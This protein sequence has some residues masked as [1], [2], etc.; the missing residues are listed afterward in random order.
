[1]DSIRLI[2]QKR[3]TKRQPFFLYFENSLFSIHRLH[4]NA[5]TMQKLLVV[6]FLKLTK[7]KPSFF[8][9]LVSLIKLFI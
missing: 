3:A 5:G 4:P 9:H 2:L 6:N 7:L 1:M 8:I